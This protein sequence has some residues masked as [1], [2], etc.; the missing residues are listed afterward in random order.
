MVFN[1]SSANLGLAKIRRV[2][3]NRER[4]Y[5]NSSDFYIKKIITKPK[6][7]NKMFVGF[8]KKL[9]RCLNDKLKFNQLNSSNVFYKLPVEA[10][11]TEFAFFR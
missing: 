3:I 8:P 5:K 7:K 11:F 2:N 4:E 9:F 10:L 1:F 6:K